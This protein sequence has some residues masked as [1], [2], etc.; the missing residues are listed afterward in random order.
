M[1]FAV[2]CSSGLKKEAEELVN[3]PGWEIF[4]R[5]LAQGKQGRLWA[6]ARLNQSINSLV[7]ESNT[8][9]DPITTL[10]LL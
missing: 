5:H 8:S 2:S 9:P 7:K 4:V 1:S 3:T 6:K 10:Y